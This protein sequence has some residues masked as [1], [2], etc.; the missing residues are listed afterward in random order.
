MPVAQIGTDAVEP[1]PLRLG[2]GSLRATP[3]GWVEH[4]LSLTNTTS[5]VLEVEPR[6]LDEVVDGMVR[7]SSGACGP[8]RRDP[9]CTPELGPLQPGQVLTT[10]VRLDRDLP[11]LAPS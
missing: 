2:L 4:D 10:V 11:G 3:G 9:P 1:G 5:D 6:V 8:V 7:A